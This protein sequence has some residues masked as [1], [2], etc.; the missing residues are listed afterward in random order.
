MWAGGRR[1]ELSA[2][3]RATAAEGR[4][5]SP[6]WRTHRARP[7]AGDGVSIAAPFLGLLTVLLVRTLEYPLDLFQLVLAD[8]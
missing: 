4:N 2:W 8:R 1:G 6:S 3:W 5:P 7:W